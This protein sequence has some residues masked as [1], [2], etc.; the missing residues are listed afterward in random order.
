MFERVYPAVRPAR[1]LPVAALISVGVHV[2]VIGVVG[3]GIPVYVRESVTEGISYFAPVPVQHQQVSGERLSFL[4][5]AG[6]GEV[7]QAMGVMDDF[8]DGATVA[9]RGSDGADST[10]GTGTLGVPSLPDFAPISF[11]S[12]YF[13]EEVDNPVAYDARSRAPAYPDSLQRL[14]IEGSVTAQF[15]VDTN[16]RAADSSLRIIDSTHTQFARSLR[17][18]LPGML[19]R[20]AEIRGTKIRQLV[21]QTFSFRIPAKGANA[22]DSAQ[23]RPP[24]ATIPP[25][26][27]SPVL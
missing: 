13:P 11:D 27:S 25:P 21:Q 1:G 12:V 23:R 14:G 18:A 16:G 24:V 15:V 22:A 8:G 3:V 7:G 9:S 10:Q 6:S 2:A 17:E 20:P 19:F 4:E 26:R 5:V